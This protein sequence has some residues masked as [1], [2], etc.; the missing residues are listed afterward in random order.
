MLNNSERTPASVSSS[1]YTTTSTTSTTSAT[2]STT[3]STSSTLS[4]N[5]S[6]VNAIVIDDR[7]ILV[8]TVPT[9]SMP[10][11]E[12]TN[13]PTD[14]P[15]DN[16]H[17]TKD[18]SNVMDVSFVAGIVVLFTICLLELCLL[19]VYKKRINAL[20]K[21][22][23]NRSPLPLVYRPY[24]TELQTPQTYNS[25]AQCSEPPLSQSR[26]KKV[27]TEFSNPGYDSDSVEKTEQ[28]TDMSF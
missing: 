22:L 1:I 6:N 14:E 2:M 17:S 4:Y 13:E 25:V 26:R 10:T 19:V 27:L 28:T 8:S 24:P 20:E 12:P 3:T 15:T 11:D 7:H 21:K 23:S 5:Q 9:V 16:L 18:D